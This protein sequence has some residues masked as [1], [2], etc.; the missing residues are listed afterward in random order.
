MLNLILTPVVKALLIINFAAFI[1]SSMVFSDLNT[2]FSLKYIFAS[3]FYPY[4][5]FTYMFLHADF[6]HVF[7]N[8]L[9]LFFIGP[10]LEMYW[11]SKKFMYFYFII[12]IG[13]GVIYSIIMYAQMYGLNLDIEAYINNP[14]FENFLSFQNKYASELTDLNKNFLHEFQ[15]NPTNPQAIEE[16]TRFAYMLF[17]AKSKSSLIGASGATYGL[18]M[19]FGL[20]F[21]Q[22][23]M[24]IFPFPV[25]I[26]AWKFI[27][28]IGAF[29]LFLGFINRNG[30]VVAHFAH[31][32]GM[33]F[34]FIMI[35][36]WKEKSQ[37]DY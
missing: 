28:G 25:P 11:G 26:K 10:I 1:I 23:E 7:F 24:M 37:E 30:D 36:L 19:A 18:L 3:N 33:L 16:S 17:D 15:Q 14:T 34:A 35:K 31:V 13:A 5:F 9:S 6:G 29:E 12:G 27:L 32:S 20:I 2:Y 4:Q 22:R 8:M 21:P